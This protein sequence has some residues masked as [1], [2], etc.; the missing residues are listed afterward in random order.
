MRIIADLHIHSK[1]ARATS[2]ALDLENLEKYARIKG[3]NLLGTGD[4]THPKWIEEIKANLSEDGTGILKSKN[5]FPFVLQTE[6]ALVYTQGGKGRRIHYLLYA[7]SLEVV[8]QINE[9]LLSKGRVDY[10]GRPIF[11]FSS[12]EL[13]EK[14]HAL[15]SEIEVIPAHAWTPWFGIFGSESGFDSLKECFQE[16]VKLIHSIETG[17][18]SDP[19]MNWR[20]SELDNITLTSNSDLHSFWPWRMGREANVFEMKELSY[21]NILAAIRERKGFTETIEVDP[22]YGKYHFD[23]HRN[24]KVSMSPAESGKVNK[25]CPA[26]R[27]EMTIGV[28]NRVEQ[29]ADRKEG[30]TPAGAIPFKR[31]MPLSELIVALNGG[32]LYSKKN[33]AAYNPILEKFGN[34]FNA[35]LNA[36]EEE[37]AKV[38]D[39]KLAAAIIANREGK[40]EVKPGYDGVYGEPALGKV[41]EEKKEEI[42]VKQQKGLGEFF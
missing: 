42:K 30:F 22:G 26:C 12:I 14:M 31:L 6:I 21:K 2:K 20:I 15:S 40:I 5:S 19:E 34:E 7:P 4:F 18:S 23:G 25:I 17:M 13:V 33:W 8:K 27:R 1:Y 32:T 16:K 36:S 3:V 28:L 11:G 41:A 29:L 38:A 35:L 39:E 37:L 10:D 9:F 24:C